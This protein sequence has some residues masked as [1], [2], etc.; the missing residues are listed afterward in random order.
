MDMTQFILKID[1]SSRSQI[2]NILFY[3][4]NLLSTNNEIN[5]LYLQSI[6]KIRVRLI[7]CD[8]KLQ[9]L[10]VLDIWKPEVNQEEEE[11]CQDQDEQLFQLIQECEEE[12]MEL[13]H[14]IHL[15][16]FPTQTIQFIIDT[17]GQRF[18]LK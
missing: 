1:C 11:F 2:K 16:S 7:W 5:L 3:L 10:N 18:W 6:K 12:I 14:E 9:D 8:N 13:F 4:Q 17:K 15:F